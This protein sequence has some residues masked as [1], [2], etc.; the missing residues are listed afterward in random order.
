VEY[1]TQI[2]TQSVCHVLLSDVLYSI[3]TLSCS[4]Y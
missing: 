3:L 2:L 4:V 1:S